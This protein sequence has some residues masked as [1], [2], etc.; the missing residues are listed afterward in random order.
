M[1]KKTK[2]KKTKARKLRKWLVGCTMEISG[3]IS[4]EAATR[5]EALELAKDAYVAHG[6]DALIYPDTYSTFASGDDGDD[7]VETIVLDE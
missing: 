4:V 3:D 6:V 1:K 7:D 2:S 5:E